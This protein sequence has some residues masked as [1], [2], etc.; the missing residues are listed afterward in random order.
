M[1]LKEAQNKLSS[2]ISQLHETYQ[3][4]STSKQ[5]FNELDVALLQQQ[6]LYI[7]HSLL[8]VQSQ[9]AQLPASVEEI[10]P[11]ITE[12][13]IAKPEHAVVTK[14]HEIIKPLDIAVAEVETVAI[15]PEEVLAP[16]NE[17]VVELETEP[18]TLASVKEPT[19]PEIK[20]P[21]LELVEV[22][23]IPKPNTLIFDFNA[24]A[25]PTLEDLEKLMEEKE[26]AEEQ[27]PQVQASLTLETTK[28]E[29]KPTVDPTPELSLLDKLSASIR[30]PDVYEKIARDQ[31]QSLK[32][33]INLNKKIAFVNNLFNENTVE[34][35]KA[36]EKLNASTTVHEALRY[37]NELK[38]QYSWSNE[39][40][41]VK[42]LEGLI[43]K[44]FA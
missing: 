28:L 2:D 26:K 21:E 22:K 29:P 19:E 16:L 42:E 35:A 5:H 9:M 10:I 24:H 37:F 13:L 38:H 40:A 7:Y 11:T 17:A 14:T 30:T 4:I 1:N 44:R 23:E 33:A 34:Y 27:V 3:L 15:T 43:E 39:N 20:T 32:Q 12:Q 6:L 31:Q 41:L 18:E 36:I 8:K 25:E